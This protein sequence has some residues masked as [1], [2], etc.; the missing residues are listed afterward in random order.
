MSV[1][2]D[3]AARGAGPRASAALHGVPPTR[4]MLTLLRRQRVPS[5]PT[6]VLQR[7]LM[8]QRRLTF[9]DA[10][11]RPLQRARRD[12][13]GAEAD[14]AP[15]FLVRVDEFPY[16]SG[17][18]EPRYG[19][20]ASVRFHDVMAEAGVP[21]LMAVVTEWTHEPLRPDSSGGRPLDDRDRDLLERMR[22]DGVTLAQ[23]GCSHRTRHTNPRRHSELCGLDDAALRALLDRGQENLAAV[24]VEAP[25]IFVP[26]FNR[27][28]ARQWPV[29][30]ERF[31]VI[32]GGPESV[33]LMGFQG[34][35]HWRDGAIY[36]PCYAPL[37][38]TASAALPAVESLI[39]EQ[40]GTWIPVVLHTSW[41]VD[42][43]FGA[44]RRLAERIAPYAMSWE[45]FLADVRASADETMST[46][47][48]RA[49]R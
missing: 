46:T 42:E 19:Y 8:K 12:A 39:A 1:R 6:R 15:R 23:H 32:T 34:G 41:E 2:P 24:G 25:T 4:E 14:G 30:A 22:A 48:E 5:R 17:Y 44:L 3:P 13:I 45:D 7:L 10:W 18:D 31:E 9:E 16:S 38:D 43:G 29:L 47:K 21:H 28:D 35:P 11:L 26:P 37:Y 40:I 20:E 49:D 36:L 33:M 27:F